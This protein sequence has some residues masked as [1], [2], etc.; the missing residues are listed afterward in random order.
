MPLS[1]RFTPLE[2]PVVPEV[3]IISEP[4]GVSCGLV[5]GMPSVSS[6]RSLP[7]TYTGTPAGAAALTTSSTRAEQTTTRAPL[8]PRM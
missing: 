8:S 5:S 2:R 6:V 4:A 7:S 3:Y 1:G